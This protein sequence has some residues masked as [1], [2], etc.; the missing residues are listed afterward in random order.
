MGARLSK[1]LIVDAGFCR[2]AA[3]WL[4]LVTAALCSP[5]DGLC[6]DQNW[7]AEVREQVRSQHLNMALVIVEHRLTEA[8]ADLEAHGWRGRLLAW[9]GRWSEAEAEYRHILQE[10]PNDIDVLTGLADVL[11]WQGRPKEAVPVLDHAREIA[12]DN[13]DILLRRARVLRQVGDARSSRAQ[14]REMLEVDPSDAAARQ[15]L[16][17]TELECRHELRIGTD[18][19]TF[20]YTD[21][22]QAQSI[23]AASRWSDRW[24]TE[25]SLS[26]YQRFRR[27]AAKVTASAILR[28]GER[29]WLG[30]A[31]GGAHDDGIIPRREAGFE[32]GHGFRFHAG[33][34]RGVEASYQQ[35]WLWYRGAHV[36][37]VGAAQTYYFP[38]DWTWRLLVS[39]ARSGFGG[40]GV[41][42]V[43][44]G[45]ARLGFPLYRRVSGNL[46]FAVG[47]ENFA[48][49]DQIG[50]FAA[51][52]YAGGVRYRFAPK[53]DVS[54]YI[55]RQ[56]RS[57]GRAQTSYGLS[58]GLRF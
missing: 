14:L 7:A 36:L 33:P 10:A 13:P 12:P 17:A 52:T 22:A 44:S 48:E 58:Y 30:A 21:A 29:D 41:E 51:R 39:G 37:T 6:R 34:L 49:I 46:A 31:M 5:P 25:V 19:D 26:T 11:V 3:A 42:W 8:P 56:D 53:Q 45:S 32:Y 15:A 43:P 18:V 4:G 47:T 55:A 50:R 40:T 9:N 38:R 1:R 54:G 20:S 35:R 24:S 27:S 16:A 57:L 2:T 28:L 23:T